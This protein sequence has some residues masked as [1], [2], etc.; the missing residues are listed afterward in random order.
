M[1]KRTSKPSKGIKLEDRDIN[2]FQAIH[3]HDGMLTLPQIDSLYWSHTDTT[4]AARVR[5][6]KLA[7]HGYLDK[8]P[9]EKQSKEEKSHPP[10]WLSEKAARLLAAL[11]YDTPNETMTKAQ[12]AKAFNLWSP[13]RNYDMVKHNT[14]VNE[15]RLK[16]EASASA[17][18]QL[19]LHAWVGERIFQQWGDVVHYSQEYLQSKK[20]VPDGYFRIRHPSKEMPGQLV[21]MAFLLE[22]DMGSHSHSKMSD[23]KFIAGRM[24]LGGGAYEARFGINHGRWLCITRSIERMK[25]LKETAEDA[26]CLGLFYFAT[27]DDIQNN[28]PLLDP[29]WLIA[30]QAEKTALIDFSR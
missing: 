24:Y 10:Y 25:N 12:F 5:L 8:L 28:N 13:K 4:S 6:N 7:R 30:G 9:R 29:I 17:H 21:E 14:W 18:D 16:I 11:R 22:V 2:T 26:H 1:S 27:F 20:V 15:F 19:S 23:E 3:E